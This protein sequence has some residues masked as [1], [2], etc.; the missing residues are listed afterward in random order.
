MTAISAQPA[1]QQGARLDFRAKRLRRFMAIVDE[2]VAR[3]GRAHIVDLGGD[4]GYWLDLEEVWRGRPLTFT[5]VN[6]TAQAHADGRFESLVG[7]CR[8]LPQFADDAFDIV[9]SNSV[10]EHVGRWADMSAFAREARRLAPRHFVQTPNYWFPLEPHFRVPFFHWML[11]PWRRALVMS[12][13]CGAFP[14]AK[15]LDQAQR[16]LEDSILVTATQMAHL[17][18]DSTIERERVYGLPKSLIAVR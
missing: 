14:K 13:A 3:K 10:V 17:F 12:R 18:P 7:D 9:H 8:A 6:I 11:E 2:V 16:F 4:V 1:L 15:D 5:I